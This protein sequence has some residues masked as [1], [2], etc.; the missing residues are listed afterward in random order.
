MNLEC[1]LLLLILSNLGDSFISSFRANVVQ[2]ESRLEKRSNTCILAAA[3]S[4]SSHRCRRHFS[5]FSVGKDR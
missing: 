4:S 5:Y 3:I 1:V 2:A